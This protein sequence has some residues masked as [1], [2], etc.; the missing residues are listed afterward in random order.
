MD[1]TYDNYLY[2]FIENVR[3][4]YYNCNSVIFD[5]LEN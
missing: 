4:F 3:Y 1:H 5:R 2:S